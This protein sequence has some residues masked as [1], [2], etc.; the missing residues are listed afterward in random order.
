M[1][2]LAQACIGSRSLPFFL[3]HFGK[4]GCLLH[5]SNDFYMYLRIA[6]HILYPKGILFQLYALMAV[7]FPLSNAILLDC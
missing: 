3:C 5:S 2:S 1:S 7:F 4:L 6:E